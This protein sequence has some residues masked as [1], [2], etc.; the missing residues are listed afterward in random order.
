MASQ[1][2]ARLGIVLGVDSGELVQGI[3][4]AQKQF[5]GLSRQGKRA[6]EALAKDMQQ[7]VYATEDFGKTLTKVELLEREIQG[8]IGVKVKVMMPYDPT[9]KNGCKVI[10]ADEVTIHDPKVVEEEQLRNPV[11]VANQQ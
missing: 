9:G 2:L 6:T 10:L 11:L 7:L 1:Y 8:I 3:T 5:D 4:E